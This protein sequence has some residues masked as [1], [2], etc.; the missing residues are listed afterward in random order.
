MT[1]K[2][3][4]KT[5]IL[6]LC[7]IS[8]YI[9]YSCSVMDYEV[10]Q[11]T[12]P[13][14]LNS[15]NGKKNVYMTEASQLAKALKMWL[16]ENRHGWTPSIISYVPRYAIY[17]KN[18]SLVVL[19]SCH[20]KRTRENRA[21][22]RCREKFLIVINYSNSDGEN[23]FQ[24]TKYVDGNIELIQE[25]L[26]NLDTITETE[27]LEANEFLE[28][29]T[30]NGTPNLDSNHNN[31]KELK[32]EKNVNDNTVKNAVLLYEESKRLHLTKLNCH[33]LAV[34]DLLQLLHSKVN[35]YQPQPESSNS[36]MAK[37]LQH[38]QLP[39]LQ[40]ELTFSYDSQSIEKKLSVLD[41]WCAIA[42]KFKLKL[43]LYYSIPDER[44]A[45]FLRKDLDPIPGFIYIGNIE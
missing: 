6:L 42:Q 13:L 34:S 41:F 26:N 29:K 39:V 33:Q 31:T 12:F 44:P 37:I 27:Q 25:L 20:C 40:K 19:P 17:S 43:S 23:R 10:R 14:K 5:V 4:F 45:F 8:A 30:L 32:L 35:I 3:K 2:N 36:F 24:Q 18:L 9:I 22:C 21:I 1:K 16:K 28:E 15:T 38:Q 7:V 11:L